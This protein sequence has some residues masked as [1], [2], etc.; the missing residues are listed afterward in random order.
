MN[1]V[2]Y[3]NCQFRGIQYFL[4]IYYREYGV[5]VTFAHIENFTLIESQG[6]IDYD[7]LHS[8]DVFIYQPIAARH[9]LYSTSSE[10]EGN[11]LARV[12]PDAQVVSIPYIYNSAFWCLIPPATIDNLVGGFG[13]EGE[14]INRVVLDQLFDAGVSLKEVLKRFKRREIDI[15]NEERFQASLSILRQKESACSVKIA[16]F[17]EAN[18]RKR[19]LFF[20]QNHPTTC[21]FVHCVN[22]V[23][24]RLGIDHSF[25]SKEYPENVAEFSKGWPHSTSDLEY[26]EFE[27]PIPKIDNSFYRKHITRIYE[28]HKRRRVHPLSYSIPEECFVDREVEKEFCF[29]PLIPGKQSTYIYQDQQSYYGMYQ[30]S[31]F[32]FTFRKGGWDCL[33]HYEIIANK[34]FPYFIGLND[35]PPSVMANFPKELVEQ[36]MSEFNSGE[37][38]KEGYVSYLDA[39]FE[40]GKQ[41]LTC[42]SS[43]MYVLEKLGLIVS[44]RD[45]NKLPRL[46]VLMLNIGKLNY[47]RELLSIG[48]RQV[49]GEDFVD[50]PRNKYIYSAEAFS[51]TNVVDDAGVNRSEI[52]KQIKERVF[53]LVIFAS[54]DLG[55]PLNAWTIPYLRLVRKYYGRDKVA[56]VF[57]GDRSITAANEQLSSLLEFG[58]C[59]VRELV[60]QTDSN[61]ALTWAE[62]VA[63]CRADW[64]PKMVECE[65]L[66]ECQE[67]L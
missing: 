28:S 12:K 10:V 67:L 46:R 11:I 8:A 66:E 47:S 5:N 42:R 2:F 64:H 18:I 20:T 38:T 26:W 31:M 59:F 57:G 24:Q 32:G 65:S 21:I 60:D 54:L 61:D 23:L 50:Y 25:D 22:Q 27:F 49:L 63:A 30:Q 58:H 51:F 53:D 35:C 37:L 4:D 52:K 44:R 14:Y 1:V 13:V 9:G 40:Y 36:C 34:C 19:R 48:L 33:R 16:D 45:V 39:V 15:Q 6:T 43:A 55:R 7:L 62:Y 56:F 17:I 29:S 3:T 41:H